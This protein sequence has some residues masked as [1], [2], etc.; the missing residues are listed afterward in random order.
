MRK[1]FIFLNVGHF[2]DH[3]FILIFPTA[4]LALQTEWARSYDDLLVYGTAGVFAFGAASIPMG[5]LGDRWSRHGMIAVFFIGIGLASIATSFATTPLQIGLG[6]GAIGVF[7][8]IYHPVGMAMVFSG[9]TN[10][11]RDLAVNGVWG[12]LGLAAAAITTAT[13]TERYGWS[14]AFLLP[15]ILSLAIGV[16]YAIA[17]GRKPDPVIAKRKSAAVSLKDHGLMVRIFFVM[18]MAAM[19]GGLVFQSTTTAL[20]KIIEQDTAG[21]TGSLSE[22]GIYAMLVFALASIA[23]L[24]IGSMIEKFQARRILFC[25]TACQALFLFLAPT[26]ADLMLLI[27]LFAMMFAVFGQIPV[28]DWLVGHYSANEWRARFYA[29]KY[30]LGLG[31]A[32]LGYWMVAFLHETYGGFDEFYIL[33]GCLMTLVALSTLLLPDN[34][35]EKAAAAPQPAE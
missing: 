20:P 14:Y 24:I 29:L 6:V 11:G 3:F 22:V 15:G 34:Q 35:T 21:I 4:V 12:N 28:N 23:Q 9:A 5:W 18:A 16:V 8:A 25:V 26:G 10:A 19:L 27:F 33:L 32:A 7:A 30:T 2:L 31:V 13:I 17:F 1:H